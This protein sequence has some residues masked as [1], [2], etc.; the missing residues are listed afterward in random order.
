MRGISEWERCGSRRSGNG[1]VR[2]FSSFFVRALLVGL[3]LEGK[4]KI[5]RISYILK[6]PVAQTVMTRRYH[7][8][9]V[10]AKVSSIITE[11][12]RRNKAMR[13][14]WETEHGAHQVMNWMMDDPSQL[15]DFAKLPFDYNACAE[16]H[17]LLYGVTA[18]E[19]R[20]FNITC[21]S[22]CNKPRL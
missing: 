11:A 13:L 15:A 8:T 7:S 9:Q 10:R 12:L 5:N 17:E 14:Q 19:I 6:K 4:K 16:F 2:P 22:C 18:P 21:T 3:E 20:K 1:R